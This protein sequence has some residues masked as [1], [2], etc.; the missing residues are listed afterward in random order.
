[1]NDGVYRSPLYYAGEIRPDD[2]DESY[3]NGEESENEEEKVSTEDALWALYTLKEL[4]DIE[5][6]RRY[7][8]DE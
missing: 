1:M 7:D 2:D 6:S 5:K 4:R 3:T 8:D